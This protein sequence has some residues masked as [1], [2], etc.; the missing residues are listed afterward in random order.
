MKQNGICTYTQSYRKLNK[1][2][3][4]T[5]RYYFNYTWMLSHDKINKWTQVKYSTPFNFFK[6]LFQILSPSPLFPSPSPPPPWIKAIWCFVSRLLIFLLF[7]ITVRVN[8]Q[9]TA[10]IQQQKRQTMGHRQ[11]VWMPRLMVLWESKWSSFIK[12]FYK[13]SNKSQNWIS[14]E[15]NLSFGTLCTA[16]CYRTW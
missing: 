6:T 1:N 10:H 9:V 7:S 14:D 16:W 2:C 13:C 11:F 3:L 8:V 5:D 15:R 12:D 4:G